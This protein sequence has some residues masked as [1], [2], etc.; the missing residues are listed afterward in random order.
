MTDSSTVSPSLLPVHYRAFYFLVAR[1][2]V[3]MMI[4]GLLVGIV[5][6]ESSRKAPY[7]ALLP[8][9]KHL[10]AVFDLALSH[11]HIFLIGALIPLAL[12]WLLFMGL[13]LGGSPISAKSL[14]V[15]SCLYFPGAVGAVGLMI[16][17]G[18]HFLLGVRGGEYDFLAL[19]ASFFGGSHAL[20][21]ATY[22]TIHSIMAIGLIIL[23][24]AFWKSLKGANKV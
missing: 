9:G 8:P 13:Q 6:Q 15:A 12:S 18:Y 19:E 17:K 21:A 3:V 16:Y 2:S 10:E 7:S 5:Y 22:G 1:F 4:L 23:V 14:K 24:V 11:G 20:R